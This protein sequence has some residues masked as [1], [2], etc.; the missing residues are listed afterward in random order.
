MNFKTSDPAIFK[1]GKLKKAKI[2]LRQGN[3]DEC[4]ATLIEGF[5]LIKVYSHN[6]PGEY[7]IF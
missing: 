2:H 4:I 1:Q 6:K 7:K 3:V 5:N